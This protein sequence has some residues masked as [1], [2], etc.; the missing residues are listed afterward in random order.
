[1]NFLSSSLGKFLV[2]GLLSDPALFPKVDLYVFPLRPDSI[3]LL[4]LSTTDLLL[5]LPGE[6]VFLDRLVSTC[7]LT[8][9]LETGSKSVSMSF[10]L[11]ML[12]LGVSWYLLIFLS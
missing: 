12:D 8:P 7:F 1:M 4:R 11:T 9:S 10:G 2:L 3:I 5:S 6:K